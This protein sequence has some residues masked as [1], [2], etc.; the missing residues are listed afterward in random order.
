MPA[1]QSSKGAAL[2]TGSVN[3]AAVRNKPGLFDRIADHFRRYWQLWVLPLP[4]CSS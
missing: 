2:Q 1:M 3:A 4:P